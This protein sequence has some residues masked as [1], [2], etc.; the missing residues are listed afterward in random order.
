MPYPHP[1]R[2]RGP[3]NWQTLPPGPPQQGRLTV[4]GDWAAAL[5]TDFQAP[6]RLTRNFRPPAQLDPHER[7]F[8][9]V[10]GVD[11]AG[12]VA[13][14]GQ[15]LGQIAA[16]PHRHEW[17]ITPLLQ[18]ANTIEI[19][20]SGDTAGSPPARP[21][22]PGRQNLPGGLIRDVVLEVRSSAWLRDAAAWTV[23]ATSSAPPSIGIQATLCE[24]A[25]HAH[26]HDNDN[27][28]PQATEPSRG[29]RQ[30]SI[31]VNRVQV[32]VREVT[33][34][35]VALSIPMA[36]G[37][38]DWNFARGAGCLVEV[39]LVAQDEILWSNRWNLALPPAER[40]SSQNVV[41]WPAFRWF[42]TVREP[43]PNLRAL[44]SDTAIYATTEI[45]A[46]EVYS[47]CSEQGIALLQAIAPAWLNALAPQLAHHPCI[48]AWTAWPASGD[49]SPVM[50][51]PAA[52]GRP[53]W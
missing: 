24:A 43:Q 23:P 16:Y 34:G 45:L 44:A 22:R 26:A 12:F 1:I 32:W 25:A 2:L 41:P 18:R 42:P 14:N 28:A 51:G 31:S 7:L 46:A 53:W 17:D 8:L 27:N 38:P 20:V 29:P 50:S 37:L 13:V 3:W 48:V 49:A 40:F 9:V 33:P 39:E 52:Y 15:A 21:L 36:Q 30:L 5:G 10:S 19:A 47:A 4:P 35:P 6:L 11:P